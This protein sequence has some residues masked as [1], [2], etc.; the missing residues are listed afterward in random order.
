MYPL[1][2]WRQLTVRSIA[3]CKTCSIEHYVV[4]LGLNL[5]LVVA[6]LD[7]V[8]DGISAPLQRFLLFLDFVLNPLKVQVPEA[9]DIFVSAVHL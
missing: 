3:Q 5:H 8:G 2:L 9:E 6:P 7:Q 4:H 1:L